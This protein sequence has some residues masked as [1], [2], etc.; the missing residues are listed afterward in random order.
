MLP[1]TTRSTRPPR[2]VGKDPG[3]L[4]EAGGRPFPAGRPCSSVAPSATIVAPKV[5]PTLRRRST[6]SIAAAADAVRARNAR[7]TAPPS[8]RQPPTSTESSTSAAPASRGTPTRTSA[9]PAPTAIRATVPGG[10]NSGRRGSGSPSRRRTSRRRALSRPGACAHAVAGRRGQG[11]RGQPRQRAGH[12]VGTERVDR[13]VDDGPRVRRS[14]DS[15][16]ISSATSPASASSS[17]PVKALPKSTTHGAA[18]P[19]DQHARRDQV[20]VGHA[21]AVQA[22]DLPPHLA[23]AGQ[24]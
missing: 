24:G 5:R 2:G 9:A 4:E 3:P 20:V 18:V 16:A 15:E 22:G 8:Q 10:P 12:G 21:G 14:S 1:A 7:A 13:R 19:V 17:A 6:V 11:Q 23:R